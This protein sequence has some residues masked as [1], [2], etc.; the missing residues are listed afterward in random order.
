VR[1]LMAGTR[2][3]PI[4]RPKGI[5]NKGGPARTYKEVIITPH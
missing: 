5:D 4:T 3:K 2:I 1:S